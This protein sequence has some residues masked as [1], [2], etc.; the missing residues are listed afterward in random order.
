MR[1]MSEVRARVDARLEQYLNDKHAAAARLGDDAAVLVDA[2]RGLTMRGGKR[3]RPAVIVATYDA[4][5]GDDAPDDL[6][7][8]LD[9]CAAL[10]V[11]Q[12]YLL[13]HDD[14]M[15]GDAERRGGPSVHTALAQRYGS[16]HLGAAVAVLAGD[17][18]SAY[19]W[20]L[21][22][23]APF[24]AGRLTDAITAFRV[25]QEEVVI[26]QHLDLLGT[27]DVSLMQH[28][29]TGSY[30][31]RGPLALGA[32]LGGARAE[33]VSSLNLFGDPLGVA[34]QLRD[35]LLGTFGDPRTTGKPAGNDLRA[36]K[37]TALVAAAERLLT[38]G[39]RAPLDA[40]LGRADAPEA[41]VAAATRLLEASGARA[42]VESQLDAH[43]S[44]ARAA[45]AVA[46][47]SARGRAR[48]TDLLVLLTERDH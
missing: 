37:R 28:L 7:P 29:K 34:F 30:T 21:L 43:R 9:V 4:V 2:V 41:D 8:T 3:L 5:R 6:T 39:E 33:Q 17:L 26:G 1:W 11:L 47:I 46:P 45:L 19:A 31:V 25:M 32:L 23:V 27:A 10:E 14:W 12:T 44:A 20:E 40:V 48:L 22:C 13:I 42:D 38:P 35:D 36:G 18:A 15:D 24:P 16:A